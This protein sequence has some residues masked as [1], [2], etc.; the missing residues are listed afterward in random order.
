MFIEE[1]TA[2]TSEIQKKGFICDIRVLRG[3]KPN[4]YAI[5][6]K[7]ASKKAVLTFIKVF[8]QQR[9]NSIEQETCTVSFLDSIRIY[10]NDRLYLLDSPDL[11]FDYGKHEDINC[12]ICLENVRS[13]FK[14]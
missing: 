6:L 14:D 9:Y 8:N 1:K 11:M 5:A 7:L 4:E 12:P 13:P 2:Q 10:T 3:Q